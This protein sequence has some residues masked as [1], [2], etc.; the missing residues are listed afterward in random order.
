MKI[1]CLIG[2]LTLLIA[3]PIFASPS[4]QA[5]QTCK[6]IGE[7]SQRLACYDALFQDV[8][9]V[10]ESTPRTPA[11]E[12]VSAELTQTPE[13]IEIPEISEQAQIEEF[14]GGHLKKN[15][16]DDELEQIS[17]SIVSITQNNAGRDIVTL[18][19]GQRW[20]AI[21]NHRLRL[22]EA[23]VVYIKRGAFN[24]FIL[25]LEG[26]NRSVRVRRIN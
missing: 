7:A 5:I 21:E 14:G 10:L 19:N 18:A 17:S 25:Q 4:E 20:R 2:G 3:A 6:S 9:E 26:S 15:S 11:Q 1:A 16:P 24:S 8:A 22:R 12:T 13:A 23:S